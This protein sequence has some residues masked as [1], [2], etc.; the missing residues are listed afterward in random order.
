MGHRR[1]GHQAVV[2]DSEVHMLGGWDSKEFLDSH[3]VYDACK[4]A[5]VPAPP[6]KSC[7]AYFAAACLDNVLYAL[8]GMQQKSVSHCLGAP[9][10]S[11]PG[12]DP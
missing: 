1:G 4:N 12:P 10:S 9:V 3:E 6:M 11:R 5:W 8:G 7:R 2:M